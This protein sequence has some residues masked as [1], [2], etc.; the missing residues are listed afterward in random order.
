MAVHHHQ[1]MGD[2]SRCMRNVTPAEADKPH[3]SQFI[4]TLTPNRL[5]ASGASLGPGM[6][7]CMV[8]GSFLTPN[9]A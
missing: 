6:L 7:T 8:L 4:E 3:F 9:H 5:C 1:F 2:M